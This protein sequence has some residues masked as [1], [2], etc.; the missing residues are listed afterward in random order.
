MRRVLSFFALVIVITASSACS[1]TA[2]MLPV[3]G[4]LSELRPVPTLQVKV[5]GV[6][7]NSGDLSWVM[8]DGAAC[9]GRWS[10]T[11]GVDVGFVSGSLLSEY[12]TTYLSGYSLASSAGT[13]RG[14]AL[15]SCSNGRTFQ[16]EFVS[17]G[18]GYGIAKDNE[19][20]IY[21][22]VF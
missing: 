7:G 20:N 18:H 12:G 14:F 17:R 9:Q 10:S 2:T 11:G 22:F 6:M 5:T 15:A 3:Q 8:P 1:L 4:P 13:N 19:D 21:R 16:V